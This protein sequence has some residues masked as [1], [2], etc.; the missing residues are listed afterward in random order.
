MIP[1]SR[2]RCSR[3]SMRHTRHEERDQRHSSNIQAR[4]SFL[5]TSLSPREAPN[6]APQ[7]CCLTPNH[8]QC[9]D[10]ISYPY[11]GDWK[12]SGGGAPL[13]GGGR[14]PEGGK[15]PRAS[16][17]SVGVRALVTNGYPVGGPAQLGAAHNGAPGV[18]GDEVL[19]PP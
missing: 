5:L 14:D 11:S 1:A 19:C 17:R 15:Q 13:A 18:G 6:S 4:H 12:I 8:Q 2:W 7:P 9:A 16:L 3:Y 10:P